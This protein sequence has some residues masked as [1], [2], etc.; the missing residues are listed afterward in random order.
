MK[1]KVVS[2]VLSKKESEKKG[3]YTHSTRNKL[4]Q[5]LESRIKEEVYF[6]NENAVH[7]Q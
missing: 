3:K 6:T 1:R 5:E 2:V 7:S 4:K